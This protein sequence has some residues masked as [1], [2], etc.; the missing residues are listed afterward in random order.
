MPKLYGQ[1]AY[2]GQRDDDD[3]MPKSRLKRREEERWRSD[4]YDEKRSTAEDEL[5]L[6]YERQSTARWNHIVS[7]MLPER[8]HDR[9]LQ[10]DAE[11]TPASSSLTKPI[12][13][14]WSDEQRMYVATTEEYP[15]LSFADDT[16][17][18][19]IEGLR[20]VAER[21]IM[22]IKDGVDKPLSKG[23]L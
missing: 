1:A 19:A 12:A 14:A 15:E 21:Y 4:W 9:F 3:P 2:Q 7:S 16:A 8:L 20:E 5:F 10:R 11:P 18:D 13:V 17:E 23:W 22:S 6:E